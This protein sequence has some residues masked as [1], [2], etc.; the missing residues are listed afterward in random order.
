MTKKQAVKITG[1][2]S[3]T[4]KMP[5][6]SYGIPAKACGVGSKLRPLA[7]S[8]CSGCYAMKGQYVFPV[9]QKAQQRR[10]ES[11][12]NPNWVTAMVTLIGDRKYFRWHDSGDLQG[13]DH[14]YKILDVCR[15]T[16]NTLHWLPTKE[17]GL[18]SDCIRA[19]G[20]QSIPENLVIRA[21]GPFID[22]KPPK[23][24]STPLPTSTVH[25]NIEPIGHECPAPKQ[26]G[27]CGDCRAC[28]DKTVANVSYK[29]H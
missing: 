14:F 20:W 3:S 9:V 22:G 12:S 6:P 13:V 27:S 15:Q 28:W 2:L 21:S 10:L 1:G 25:K 8:V 18:V 24:L 5:C 4:G 26:G 29:K 19:N 23:S 7:N 17:I 16:L 11:I